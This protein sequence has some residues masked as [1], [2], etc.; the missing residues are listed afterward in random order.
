MLPFLKVLHKILLDHFTSIKPAVISANYC[1]TIY[2]SIRQA[3]VSVLP[4][5]SASSHV[6]A[7]PATPIRN[8][9]V[10]PS[11]RGST[12]TFSVNTGLA[13]MLNERG[14]SKGDNSSFAPTATPANSPTASRPG[15]P[16]PEGYKLPGEL[17]FQ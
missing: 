6:P 2:C 7:T 8:P 11:R 17:T 9:S 12:A 15:S 10:P 5:S 13:K 16:E 1:I 4:T 14:T 3:Q